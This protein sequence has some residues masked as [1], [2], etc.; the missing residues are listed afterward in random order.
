MF[1]GLITNRT[2][3]P[4][5]ASAAR[6]RRARPRYSPSAKVSSAAAVV[7]VAG[8]V[9]RSVV[10]LVRRGLRRLA[11]GVVADDVGLDGLAGV[12]EHVQVVADPAGVAAVGAVL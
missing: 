2:S 3:T 11:V 5:R 4:R 6:T 1:A 8:D 12:V 7:R 10:V 9:R